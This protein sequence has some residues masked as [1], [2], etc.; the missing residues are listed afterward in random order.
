MTMN[1]VDWIVLLK[2]EGR[3]FRP[4]AELP[5]TPGPSLCQD[6]ETPSSF[7]RLLDYNSSYPLNET[8]VLQA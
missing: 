2:N 8:L 7:L 1:G 5:A 4:I 3:V 6:P